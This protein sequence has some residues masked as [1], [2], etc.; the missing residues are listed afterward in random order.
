MILI[1]SQ[2]NEHTTC[3]V[4]DWLQSMSVP[5][6]RINGLDSFYTISYEINNEQTTVHEHSKLKYPV[7]WYRRWLEQDYFYLNSEVTSSKAVNRSIFEYLRKEGTEFK[8]FT[9]GKLE[10]DYLLSNFNCTSLNKLKVLELAK[11]AG[12]TIPASMVTS[13]KKHLADFLQRHQAIIVKNIAD[14]TFLKFKGQFYA[15]YTSTLDSDIFDSMPD[16]FFPSLVQQYIAKKYEVRTFY[17]EGKCYSMAIFSQSNSKTQVDF[18]KYDYSNPNRN[19]PYQLPAQA[20]AMVHSLMQKLGLNSGSVDFIKGEDDNFYFLEINPLGQFGMV[21]EPCNYHL[22]EK[23][24]SLLASKYEHYEAQQ[25]KA[26]Q[27]LAVEYA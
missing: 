8:S 9:L 25:K 2:N 22:E 20:E 23:V 6:K 26:A 17:L 27:P 14:A 7:A 16:S 15:T 4:M 13:S 21:S 11:E 12:L 5:V 19:V 18:R 1:I 24:A 3:L 10:C